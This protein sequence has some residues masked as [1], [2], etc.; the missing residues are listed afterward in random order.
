V[1][2]T[3]ALLV[4][5]Y[6]SSYGPMPAMTIERTGAGAG[7]RDLGRFPNA[8]RVFV[9]TRA[10]P[11]GNAADCPPLGDETILKIECE[12]DDMNPQLFGVASDRLFELGAVDVFLTAVQM[13]KG[14]PG[15]LLTVLAPEA[16]RQTLVNVIFRETTTLGVRV[17]RVWRETL[18]RAI[19]EVVISGG[20]VRVKVASRAGEILNAVP[21]FDDCVRVSRANGQPVKEVQ[22]EALRAWHA[23]RAPTASS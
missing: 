9:G 10:M 22:A 20:P 23:T 18:E 8:V 21:E 14:R 19:V 3:G 12:I 13:K 17:E 4:S 5:S 6:A 15:T 1:T 2:P 16:L 7:R 11:A